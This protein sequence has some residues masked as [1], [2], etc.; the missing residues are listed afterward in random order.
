MVEARLLGLYGEAGAAAR[1][2]RSL[3][4]RGLTRVESFA[5][6]PD[7]RIEQALQPRAS[8]VRAYTLAGGV[9]GGAAG[10]ALP[11]WTSLGWPLMT[12]GKPIVSMPAFLVI[13]FETAILFGALFTLAG[14]LINARLPRGPGPAY[15]PRFSAD[16]FGV[17]VTTAG[18]EE[19]QAARELLAAAGALEVRAA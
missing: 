13:A 2:I 4:E 6:V 8:P 5:P 16:H 15:D 11:I 14:F 18:P 10:L 17:L 12:G 3:R 9:L 1:A 7:P 19:G